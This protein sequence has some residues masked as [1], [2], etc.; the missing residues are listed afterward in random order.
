MDIKHKLHILVIDDNA[1]G[2]DL[3][4]D[5]LTMLGH[6]AIAAYD[7]VEGVAAA[8]A[9]RPDLILLDLNMPKLDGFQV[10]TCLR[11]ARST[12]QILLV[13]YSAMSDA[14]TITRLDDEGFDFR[15]AKPAS[16]TAISDVIAKAS[17]RIT[18]LVPRATTAPGAA[19]G[20]MA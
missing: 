9:F 12:K 8:N 16:L 1:E 3:M 2:A 5:L 15:L 13:A 17:E 10:A 7:G 20:Q 14:A 18:A 19:I 11:A 4:V 6:E